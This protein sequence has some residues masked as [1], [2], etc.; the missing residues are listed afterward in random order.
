[1]D[2]KK[3]F[4]STDPD[5]LQKIAEDS[6]NE[7]LERMLPIL[8][9]TANYTAYLVMQKLAEAME[10]G[11]SADLATPPP[12]AQAPAAQTP[13]TGNR[14]NADSR[15]NPIQ[16]GLDMKQVHDAVAEALATQNASKIIPFVQAVGGKHPE[17][18]NEII[19]AVKVELH[20][21]IMKQ[22]IDEESAVQI[23]QALN[24]MVEA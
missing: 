15:P 22:L 17:V 19:K 2:M 21:A 9:K 5:I 14:S 6:Q 23:S 11:V 12:A 13:A 10:G 4:E 8:E 1:M 3:F 18:L 7:L 24:G 16:G 20:D